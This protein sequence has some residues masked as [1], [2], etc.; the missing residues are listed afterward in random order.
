MTCDPERPCEA[1]DNGQPHGLAAQLEARADGVDRGAVDPPTETSRLLRKAAEGLRE[2]E[3]HLGH[4]LHG[5]ESWKHTAAVNK[6]EA[7]EWH[8]RY[9]QAVD[10]DAEVEARTKG[11]NHAWNAAVMAGGRASREV[12]EKAF[13]DRS[14]TP[15]EGAREEC[16]CDHD[17][18]YL[19][20]PVHD[21]ATEGARVDPEDLTR[22]FDAV[23]H[24]HEAYVT[25]YPIPTDPARKSLR[26]GLTRAAL[27]ALSGEPSRVDSSQ[28]HN[29]GE[30]RAKSEEWAE[31]VIS[32]DPL[33]SLAILTERHAREGKRLT[34]GP[35]Y[36]AEIHA[37]L[38]GE[39][40]GRVERCPRC[41]STDPAVIGLQCDMHEP[42]PF[43]DARVDAA[44]S[45]SGEG[46]ARTEYRVFFDGALESLAISVNSPLEAEIVMKRQHGGVLEQRT[47]TDWTPVRP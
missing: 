41:G 37:A 5:Q 30:E 40:E 34:I 28:L 8:R 38:S 24:D 1:C 46:E 33:R 6:A 12:W 3:Q 21:P 16:I 22:A 13:P 27:A 44:L 15:T 31:R 11:E 9:E 26:A 20:C 17:G 35:T 23:L 2:L 45:D 47:I 14:A 18:N 7:D 4:A 25:G 43:H 10:P 19:N 32:P 42:H 29:G 36:C 39:G